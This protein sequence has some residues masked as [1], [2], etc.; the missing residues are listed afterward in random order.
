MLY[1]PNISQAV[2]GAWI[3]EHI[4]SDRASINWID[5]LVDAA[6]SIGNDVE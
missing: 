6:I 2:G 4:A 1:G 5:E 3:T